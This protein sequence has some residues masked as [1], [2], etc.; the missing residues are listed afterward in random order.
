MDPDGHCLH[1]LPTQEGQDRF[2]YSIGFAESYAAP[3]VLIFGL[4]QQKAHALLNEC[5]VLLKSG[6]GIQPN[7]EDPDVLAG[8]YKVV[9]R[10]VRQDCL[11]QYLGTALRYY[12][13][14]PFGAVVMFIPD[15]HHRFSWQSGYDGTPAKESL[16][17]VEG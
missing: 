5:A 10:P 9:F 8:G 15:R 11:G 7:V 16:T 1:V 6:R 2:T 17:I 4:E 13:A 14:R 12:Q 3:E